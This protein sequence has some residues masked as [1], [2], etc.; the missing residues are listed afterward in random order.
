MPLGVFCV[1]RSTVTTLSLAPEVQPLIARSGGVAAPSKE[2][3]VPS[4]L[5]T[6]LTLHGVAEPTVPSST[7]VEPA[8]A[9]VTVHEL[10]AVLVQVKVT[11]CTTPSESYTCICVVSVSKAAADA[12]RLR[13]SWMEV[14]ERALPE[15]VL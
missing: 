15:T 11:S 8:A 3:G 4:P 12:G 10:A 5:N 13:P 1:P 14:V 7:A 6:M 2:A 9:A